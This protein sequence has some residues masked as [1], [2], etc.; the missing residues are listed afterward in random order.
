MTDGPGG[1]HPEGYRVD[2]VTPKKMPWHK[3][4]GLASLVV[5]IVFSLYQWFDWEIDRRPVVPAAYELMTRWTNTPVQRDGL[6]YRPLLPMI[7]DAMIDEVVYQGEWRDIKRAQETIKREHERQ[8]L[9]R[10]L[11]SNKISG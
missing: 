10:V 6:D 5:A 4:L 11:R 8:R 9:I 7:R 2:D 1:P 3:Q